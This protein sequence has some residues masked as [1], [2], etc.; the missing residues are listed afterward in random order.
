MGCK[1][2]MA[3]N[4]DCAMEHSVARD[5]RDDQLKARFSLLPA[6]ALNHVAMA[7]TLGEEKHTHDDFEANPDMR[8]ANTEYDAVFR[9]YVAWRCGA[10]EDTETRLHPLAHAAARALIA[11]QL[12]LDWEE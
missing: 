11:L 1:I 6:Q 10:R 8:D 4:L 12:A 7:L 9:H 5:N 3:Q 2:G